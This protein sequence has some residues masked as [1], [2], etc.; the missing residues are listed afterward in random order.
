L[1]TKLYKQILAAEDFLLFK[2]IM[3]QRNLDVEEQ[4]G[5][6]P[7]EARLRPASLATDGEKTILLKVS[8]DEYERQRSP[9]RDS[10]SP[11]SSLPP[12]QENWLVSSVAEQLRKDKAAADS[13]P[14]QAAVSTNYC[15]IQCQKTA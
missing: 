8:K 1:Y 12:K 13:K 11:L 6:M 3:V 15:R 9:G 7:P 4:F 5:R 14:V 2:S 10:V